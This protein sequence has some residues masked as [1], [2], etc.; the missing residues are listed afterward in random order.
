M[1]RTA[2][3]AI[4]GLL[5]LAAIAAF[6][7]GP[8]RLWTTIGGARK[9]VGQEIDDAKSD[10]Q[11]AAELEVLL[12][13]M[14]EDVETYADKLA[15]V[16]DRRAGW[17]R[18]SQDIGQALG[19]QRGI[20][21]RAKDLLEQGQDVYLIGTR[22]H[23]RQQVNDDAKARL[24]HCKQLVQEAEWSKGVVDQLSQSVDEGRKALS[25]AQGSRQGIAAKLEMLQARL[26]NARLMAQ[27]HDAVEHLRASPL[28]PRSELAR[29]LGRFEARVKKAERYVERRAHGFQGG[30]TVDWE[31]A[32]PGV[33]TAKEIAD[34]LGQAEAEDVAVRSE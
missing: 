14:D 25:E 1:F 24:A 9:V 16:E 27:V 6:L 3:Y 5:V 21:A 19:T 13:G 18:R 11:L 33:D 23:T 8:D 34:F 30:M 32:S 10:V 7:L 17:E 4:G 31:D 12:E 15:D 2:L 26:T 22:S 29:Q 28:E 20:L